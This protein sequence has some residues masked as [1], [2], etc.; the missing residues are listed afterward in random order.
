MVGVLNKIWGTAVIV[1]FCS[2][3]F[4]QEGSLRMQ[5]ILASSD[6]LVIDSL[7][8]YKPSFRITCNGVEITENEYYL[9]PISRKFS[10]S[11]SCGDSLFIAYRVFDINL[12]KTYQKKDT[13][14]LYRKAGNIEDFVYRIDNQ[15]DDFFG[16][17]SI[18]KS[19]S[20]SRGISFGNS[21]DLSV[22]SSLNL[23]LA[24]DV[25][26]DMKILATVTDDN[27]PIQ[28]DGTTNRLQEFDQVFIQ[29][30]GDKYK[31]I[32][33]DF[34]L[35]KPK[36]HFMNYNKRAQGLY[37]QYN[38]ENENGGK[39]R[40]QGAGA[41]SKGKFARNVIQGVEAN[42]GPYRLRGNENEPFIIV[43]SG[44]EQVYLDGKLMKRGQEF[45]YVINYN[46]SEVTFTPKNQITKDVRIVVEFQYT[47][48]NYARSLFQS[49]LDYEGE[50]FAFWFNMYSEQD[51]KNQTLQ[52]DLS[53]QDRQLLSDIGDSVQLARTTAI[54]S[55][56]F[57]DSQ[58]TYKLVDSLG[59][60]SVLVHSVNPDSSIY[61]AVFTEVGQGNGDYIFDRFTAVGRIYK[62]VAPIA[63]VKQGNFAPVRLIITPKRNTMISTGFKLNIAKNFWISTEF[64]G[65]NTD[66]NTFSTKDSN[67]N[68]AWGNNTK[69]KGIFDLGGDSISQWRFVTDA[70][71]EYRTLNF[72]PIERYRSVEFDRDW[73]VRGRDFTGQ[74]LLANAKGTFE[75]DV[76]GNIGL[77]AQNFTLGQDYQGNRARFFGDWDKNGWKANWNGSL[78]S[79]QSENRNTYLR[80]V[81][82]IS[83]EIKFFR[84]GFKDDHELNQF[85]QGDTLLRTDS[86]QWYDWQVYLAE[87]EDSENGFNIFYRERYDRRSDSSSLLS[88]AR[89]RSFG[90]SYNWI[91]NKA[92]KLNALL[93]YRSLEI[94]DPNLINEDPENTLLGRI[95][96]NLRVF[97][98]ALTANTF[99]EVGSGLELRKEFLYIEVNPGQGVY[100]WIDYNSDGIKDLN[101]FEVAQYADQA[102]Y[103]RVFTP[104]NE[105]ERTFSNEFNQ[106]FFWRPERIWSNES[107]IKKLLSRFSNQSRFRIARKTTV[108]DASSFNPASR[109]IADTSLLSF[110]STVRNTIYF[111]RTNPIFG[112]DYTYSDVGGKTLLANGFDA[113]TTR[114]NQFNVRWNIKKQFTLTAATE[115]G[116]R[117]SQADY[118]TGRDFNIAYLK[119]QPSFIFQPNTKFRVSL[120]LR[121]ENKT[122][123]E[124][125]GGEQANIQDIGVN[126]KLNQAEKGSL[127]SGINMVRIEYDGAQNNALA[128]E[129]LEA[130]RP[131]TN[132]TWNIGYQRSISKN[133]QVS[134]QYNGRKSEGNDA[135]H[136]GGVE[137]RAFF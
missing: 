1:L 65:T 40:A 33:G 122:N 39:W 117:G 79:S 48:Q 114:F 89:A 59:I 68:G 54:D 13:S 132:F 94:D 7:T 34:W 32:A 95:D 29:L 111:N 38:W 2:A 57:N 121:Q 17:S 115:I 63:G 50:K 118:T 62:W 125:F 22:N 113:R 44:T 60:D 23:Q 25:T 70:E 124:V 24:G 53:Q 109:E 90:A 10:Y 58:V 107:G 35:K 69:L 19:G 101:E 129:M 36:G 135:I 110:N 83:K 30:Y 72:Q 130:L 99:Y 86:Y 64:S 5:K 67:D 55:I 120:D 91:T 21:Q 61:R 133:L 8:I 100:T 16:G 81:A 73:N 126:L 103:I 51:A 9:N 49:S 102:S 3:L 18:Q 137:V 46:T 88:A 27:I 131:G 84:I 43:L 123:D 105:Y 78:L 4:G 134:I 41:L 11:G 136:A 56:G 77:E 116:E 104:T 28:P 42:Q 112:A 80:H 106:S 12:A 92:S 93:S 37:A 6:T 127:T 15:T 66:F 75:N 96:Y 98:G 97:K 20:L 128:F 31:I 87:T 119:V 85:N 52:Q 76:Y 47:D 108:Q 26:E 14:M 74:E 71:V 82:D 45:D